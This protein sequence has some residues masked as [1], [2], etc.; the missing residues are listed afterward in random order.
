MIFFLIP[1]ILEINNIL[2]NSPWVKKKIE[3]YLKLNNN[4]NS[5]S[6]KQFS[7]EKIIALNECFRK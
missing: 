5:L 3:E 4:K 7:E 1:H 6:K 2:E